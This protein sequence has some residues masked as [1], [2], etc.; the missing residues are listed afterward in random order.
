MICLKWKVEKKTK[1]NT[2]IFEEIKLLNQTKE[3]N[4]NARRKRNCLWILER[5]DNKQAKMKE[6][7]KKKTITQTSK[8]SSGNQALQHKSHQR[9]I[10]GVSHLYDTQD[11]S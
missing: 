7:E 5:N 4:Q 1:K 9:E 8:K 10:P 2:Q 6:K 11:H 3:K